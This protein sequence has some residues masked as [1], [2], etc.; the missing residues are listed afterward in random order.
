[1]ASYSSVWTFDCTIQPVSSSDWF[2][3]A[4]MYKFKKLFTEYDW[5]KNWDKMVIDSITY[6]VKEVKV[7][8]WIIWDYNICFIQESEW[9]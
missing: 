9:S 8:E 3:G 2:D 7:W 4:T 6:I 5:I 1:M